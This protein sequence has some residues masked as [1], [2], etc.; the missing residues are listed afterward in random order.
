MTQTLSSPQPMAQ[1]SATPPV[2]DP[3]QWLN[4]PVF[5]DKVG[6]S[7]S[8]DLKPLVIGLDPSGLR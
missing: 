6:R 7:M 1:L 8:H 5:T 3:T 2:F 4:D